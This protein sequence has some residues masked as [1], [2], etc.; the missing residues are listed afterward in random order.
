MSTDI[1]VLVAESPVTVLLDDNAFDAF[2]AHVENEI[3]IAPVDLSTVKG[4]KE[5]G[6]LAYKITRSKTAIDA[7]GKEL[8]EEARKRIDS[9]NACRRKVKTVL[10][11][12]AE[13]ARK[14]LTDWENAEET[15]IKR[16]RSVIDAIQA[17]GNGLIEGQTEIAEALREHVRKLSDIVL[18]GE[19]AEFTAE[20]RAAVADALIKIDAI[21]VRQKE[22]ERQDA[23]MYRL[24]AEL[25]ELKAKHEAAPAAEPVAA[26][27]PAAEAPDERTARMTQMK[28]AIMNEGFEEAQAKTVVM[29]I[30]KGRI[31]HVVA[32]LN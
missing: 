11:A 19:L 25:A 31:P 23:E 15:R 13:K 12:L 9:V 18:T 20:A 17:C 16:A 32:S 21:E 5:V 6:S 1:A 22:Q 3:S 26:P 2:V 4:R 10:D 14:P 29:A 27:A 24:R 28:L 8:T 7:A 30:V